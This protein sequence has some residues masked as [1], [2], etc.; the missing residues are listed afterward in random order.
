MNKYL[1]FIYLLFFIFCFQ[2]I[3]LKSQTDF[4]SEQELKKEAT[5]LFE[6]EEFVKAYPLYTQLVS[7]YKKD[8]DYNYRL[9]VCML[10][11]VEDKEKAIPYLQLALK[12]P[13]EIEKEAYFYLAKAYHLNYRFDDAIRQ[14]KT[15]KKVASG[16]KAE[17]LQVDRQIEMCANGKSLLR[18]LSDLQ[19]IEKTEM[20]REDFFRTYN[21][22]TIG[23][24]LL[25]KP[26]EKEFRTP[27][28]KKKKES[29]ILY[30]AQNGSNIYFSSYGENEKNGKDIY[31]IKKTS[32]GEWGN[33]QPL[34][35]V[36]NTKYDEDFPFMHP[37]GKVLYF[38]SKGHN[39][40]GGY[41]IFKSTLNEKN[42][43][44]T[45]VNLDFP[46]NTPDDDILYITDKDE[47]TAY[48]SS[49]RA[50]EAG[51]I[52]VYNINIERRA[53]DF[54]FI[55]G[56]YLK[57]RDRQVLNAKIT[58][59]NLSENNSIVGMFNT[60]PEDGAY[61]IRL[62]NNGGKFL[63]TVEAEGFL[64]QSNIVE[65]P[66]QK[67]F[68]PLRQE[69]SFDGISDTLT[70]RN[71]FDESISDTS[72]M[73]SLALIKEKS[74]LSV[75][76]PVDFASTS[77]IEKT[78]TTAVDSS[79]IIA[80]TTKT[81]TSAAY[82]KELTNEDIVRIGY[83]DAKEAEAEAKEVR[84]QAD[85]SW[86]FANQKN[87][88]A[89]AKLAEAKRL[90][91]AVAKEEDGAKKA[92]LAEQAENATKEA[93]LLNEE[94]VAA[95]NIAKKIESTAIAKQE[96]ADLSMQYAKG[97]DAAVNST[98]SKE[99]V[100]KL[101]ELEKKLEALTA[102]N[103]TSMPIINSFKKDEENKKRELDRAIQD[104]N[105]LKQDMADN[106]TIIAGLKVE[107]EKE[108]NDKI[109]QSLTNQIEILKK[110]NVEKQQELKENDLKV[111]R[112]EKEYIGVKNEMLFV[113]NV[114]S[115]SKSTEGETLA[116][117]A[118]TIDKN[119]LEQQVNSLKTETASVTTS[120][121]S[122]NTNTTTPVVTTTEPVVTTTNSTPAKRDS[123]LV[124]K[125]EVQAPGIDTTS[126]TVAT[127]AQT[128]P[129]LTYTNPA[130]VA[131]LTEAELLDKEANDLLE[132]S[133]DLAVNPDDTSLSKSEQK[134]RKR[135]SEDLAKQAQ[136]KKEKSEQLYANANTTEYTTN[137]QLLDEAAKL[138]AGSTAPEVFKAELLNDE[139]KKYF[140]LAKTESEKANSLKKYSE[141]EAAWETAKSNELIALEKQKEA[142][143]IYGAVPKTTT[144]TVAQNDANNTATNV[145]N[146]N[147]STSGNQ[148]YGTVDAAPLTSEAL[149][150]TVNAK[151]ESDLEAANSIKDEAD[152]EKTKADILK[153]WTN[154]INNDI[155][156]QKQQIAAT[157]DPKKKTELETRLQQS[158]KSAKEKQDL[159]VQSQAKAE[160]IK[161]QQLIAASNT[162]T[163]TNTASN[164]TVN[165]SATNNIVESPVNANVA[166]NTIE[167]KDNNE[168]VDST[169][170]NEQP[171]Y[172][173]SDPVASQQVEKA[174]MM[175]DEA[176]ALLAESILPQLESTENLSEAEQKKRKEN[177][178]KLIE[179]A[180]AKKMESSQLI[181]TANSSEYKQK[182]KQVDALAKANAGNNSADMLKAEILNDESQKYFNKAAEQRQKAT[183]TADYYDKED[184]LLEA[185]QNE[186]L[187]LNKQ[188]QAIDIYNNPSSAT[189]ASTTT[190]TSNN[191]TKSISIEPTST[192]N[193]TASN[194]TDVASVNT[195]SEPKKQYVYSNTSAMEQSVKAAALNKQAEDIMTLSLD[196]KTQ[197]IAQSNA[198]AKNTM[199]AQSEELMKEARAKKT[200]AAQ[201]IA[202][203]NASEYNSNKQQL[204]QYKKETAGN[205]AG[206]LL[207]AEVLGD[208]AEDV[209]AKAK[210]KR[211]EATSTD[212]YYAK[213]NLLDEAATNEIEAIEK[214]KQAIAIYKKYKPDF[215]A[216][217]TTAPKNTTTTTA[218]VNNQ[219]VVN[220][221]S[222]SSSDIVLAPN[223]AFEEKAIP[224]YSSKNPIPIDSKIPEGL[225]FKVQ[226]GAFRKPIP[227]N[228]FKGITPLTGETTS[229]GFIRY[230]AGVFTKF[231]TADKAK[232]KIIDMGYKDAFVVA[233]YNGKRI[234]I[235]EAY[236]MA[237]GVPTNVLQTNQATN[238]TTAVAT[239]TSTSVEPTNS[240]EIAKANDLTKVGGLFYT[241][242]VGVYAQQVKASKLYNMSPLYNEKAPNGYIRYYTG[243][244]KSVARAEEAK[245][246]VMDIGIKDAFITAYY[247]GK[248]I[249]VAEAQKYES[250]GG[251]VFP[252]SPDVNKLPS[253]GAGNA[254]SVN[255][256]SNN[257]TTATANQSNT[258]A[259]VKNAVAGVVFKIQIGAFKEEVPLEIANKFILIAKKGIET[260]TDKSGLTIY[261]VGTCKTYEEASALKT[262][263]D[264]AD[265]KDSF[266]VAYKNGEKVALED[267]R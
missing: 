28:D 205:N 261:T 92:S 214:Q 152:R 227:Q 91:D 264:A 225:I 141:K 32:S 193:N 37:N 237:G 257:A 102:N 55:K 137:Q 134:D 89:Q 86:A 84:E 166:T 73:L 48:F 85:I 254:S 16:A 163:N 132:K 267:V 171:T 51:K 226:V 46:I 243:I 192:D 10:Y 229:K 38:C 245:E 58:I 88:Q 54:V 53:L 95:F 165:N 5:K 13:N 61:D 230:T 29:S 119:K 80:S 159:A 41:D 202:D 24:K 43:W 224:V 45:P 7:L 114:V 39:S 100:A 233:F 212:S 256:V 173:Y 127:V 182:Q 90:N 6:N 235:N 1:K 65:V 30:L 21:I 184:L 70:I 96:E 250:Q 140:E 170:E 123:A 107:I 139:A 108:K 251:V 42:E 124:V 258:K 75:S 185:Q 240:P 208:E 113:S 155:E 9:G 195:P 129:L 175:N 204:E 83:R 27:L 138:N 167:P 179:Q 19:V 104:S 262:E 78:S 249:S 247:N 116:A 40:M 158:E 196:L 94:T 178:R 216:T 156:K 260:Y 99:A 213:E 126:A 118:A 71:Y 172:D 143:A 153:S 265:L 169:D 15:Y 103:A 160:S 117:Q 162:T 206:E 87:E 241:V 142:A 219:T 22:S 198:D 187:A 49:A 31:Q 150:A 66:T 135:K 62:P 56:K 147:A 207:K 112:L 76:P 98:N 64:P 223:E 23:G 238:T 109:K 222:A 221:S 236:A 211:V 120:S 149:M 59:K 263:V 188:K 50:S 20:G 52:A 244:Y 17:R 34:S 72:Y 218:P 125:T 242:Q 217:S 186:L 12:S 183:K 252:N 133:I 259:P 255:S 228:L 194:T 93:Q 11:T 18:N 174:V 82:A 189:V 14:Y 121:D 105:N 190:T 130:A 110:E 57:N 136:D 106:E 180:Q 128:E 148:T 144:A 97:L 4:T 131:Q 231:A 3:E 35:N 101:D 234:P 44:S 74:K 47:K 79:A 246:M 266:I 33:P 69:F 146:N 239:N 177:A 60:D 248:R 145:V 122:Q 36:I 232:K 197:A 25:V 157:T 200:E 154:E 68:K 220:N 115:Q 67:E 81:D 203:A 2:A 26:D 111:A 164:N 181:A 201:L 199:Y 8:P 209:Y 253:F 168:A 161:Q 77:E 176:D 191:Q 210:T 151:Y 215:V 63:F